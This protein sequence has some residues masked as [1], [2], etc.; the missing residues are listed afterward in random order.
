MT[1]RKKRILVSI[2]WL[3]VIS[4]GLISNHADSIFI[5]IVKAVLFVAAVF[6]FYWVMVSDNNSNRN[7]K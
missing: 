7:H 6:I 2:L 1:T 3:L 5:N 4:D